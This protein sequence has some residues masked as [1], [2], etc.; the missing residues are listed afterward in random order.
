MWGGVLTRGPQAHT[1]LGE[2]GLLQGPYDPLIRR[3]LM[4]TGL[5]W[6]NQGPRWVCGSEGGTLAGGGPPTSDQLEG[7]AALWGPP[8][9][10]FLVP[11]EQ[12]LKR[13]LLEVAFPEDGPRTCVSFHAR[14]EHVPR[15]MPGGASCRQERAAEKR[16]SPSETRLGQ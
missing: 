9:P 3:L 11:Q 13:R 10:H 2:Q 14:G 8:S 4:H 7:Q 15:A 12:Q 1:G 16:V 6:Q 5:G